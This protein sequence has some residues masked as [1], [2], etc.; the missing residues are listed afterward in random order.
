V[1]ESVE[2]PGET[3][4]E[5]GVA[6]DLVDPALLIRTGHSKLRDALPTLLEQ[7]AAGG[8]PL[9]RGFGVEDDPR[10]L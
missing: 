2:V 8:R 5:A 3:A 10:S 4:D 6:S 7:L 1:R 9:A